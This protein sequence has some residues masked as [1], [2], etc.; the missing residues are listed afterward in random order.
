[1]PAAAGKLSNGEAF[2]H[3]LEFQKWER[4]TAEVAMPRRVAMASVYAVTSL[5][6]IS[7]NPC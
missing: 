2:K 3:G 7:E 6:R 5:G 4:L 1:M